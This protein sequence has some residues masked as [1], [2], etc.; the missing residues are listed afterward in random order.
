MK[1]AID[2]NIKMW[3]GKC[4]ACTKGADCDLYHHRLTVCA[5][6]GF[7]FGCQATIEQREEEK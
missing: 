4:Q 3:C 5:E 6:C 2:S 1:A 7:C